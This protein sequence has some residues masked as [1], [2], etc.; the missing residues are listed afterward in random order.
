M[1]TAVKERWLRWAEVPRQV[2]EEA[3]SVVQLCDRLLAE[4]ARADASLRFLDHQLPQ[5]ATEFS[6]QWAGVVAGPPDW[7]T[8]AGCGRRAFSQ[9]PIHYL[10]EV[11][12]R[13]AGGLVGLDEPA[14]WVLAAVP[15]ADVQEQNRLL[16]LAGKSLQAET[17]PMIVAVGRV[18]GHCL[19]ATAQRERD[20][21]RIE[22]LQ[23][24]LQ[25]TS[26]FAQQRKSGRLLEVIAQEATRLL[27]CDRAS[28]FI[29]DRERHEL[30]ACPALGLQELRIPDD[31]GVVGE[32]L[33]SGM[34]I[35]VD[36]AYADT[37][38]SREVDKQSGYRTQ[39]LIGVPMRDTEG[40]LVGVFEAVNKSG[41]PFNSD[42]EESLMQLGV[43]AVTA[44][45][46]TREWEELIRSRDQ[47]TEQFAQQVQLVGQSPAITALRETVK[48]LAATDLPVLLT[49]ESG[50]GKEVVA[51][52]LHFEGP[53]ASR[54]FVAVNCA[55]LTETLMESE[56]FG[57][58][59]GAFTDAHEARAGK[60]ELAEG[61]TL[62]LDEI[63]DMSLGGQ[64]KLLR[65][66]EQKVVTRVGGS[67]P[68]PINVRIVAATN[69]NLAEAVR[70]K[71]FREDLYYR[72]GVVTQSLPAL[73]ERPEDILPLAEFFLQRFRVD[74]NRPGLQL[75][76]E[77]R[78]RL[79]AHSW[80]GNV[81]EL[82]NLIERVAFLSPAD[83]I[84]ADDLAFILS[85]EPSAVL[86][87][88]ADLGLA[89]ATHEFQKEFIRRAVKR[90]GGNMSEAARLLGLHRSNLYRK[91]RQL[92]MTD[93]D[94]SSG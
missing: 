88:S 7:Q 26:S 54:P 36:D 72:L 21:L 17:L 22:R 65:V 1:A 40:N 29:W 76:P 33:Q 75:S 91:M 83:R 16:L 15:A 13:D 77:A 71:R 63:G 68:I 31:K 62:F 43:H 48:R 11:L 85:P 46:N 87:P 9:L 94:V 42:D 24:T 25:I 35:R 74:A 78:R 80:P 41:G 49:G 93:Q 79:Q 28:I 53:R 52:A 44:M 64:A 4:S 89:M 5:I 47:W 84:E 34:P 92:G 67:Q 82:R 73:R 66:L 51:Q 38:F 45:R 14:N 55:A 23:S 60:F 58:E 50:T 6:A 56:L 2:D 57:H 90:V 18:L 12:D 3:A 81:R 19:T 39:N 37:R 27:D 59:K 86:E 61:G 8:L 30:V 10:S 20:A 70:E 32:V 69:K